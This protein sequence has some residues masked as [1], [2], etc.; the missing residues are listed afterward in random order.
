MTHESIFEIYH[1]VCKNT[2]FYTNYIRVIFTTVLRR[3]F[4]TA[5]EHRVCETGVKQVFTHVT[6]WTSP[7]GTCRF[8]SSAATPARACAMVAPAKVKGQASLKKQS[9]LLS[10]PPPCRV[11][12]GLVCRSG[13]KHMAPAERLSSRRVSVSGEKKNRQ[14]RESAP[15]GGDSDECT[16]FNFR[17]T[18]FLVR[19]V[20][21]WICRYLEGKAQSR[22]LLALSK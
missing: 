8:C 9:L 22:W 19:S 4:F 3:I 1:M 20:M 15:R 18:H 7:M 2:I 6:F 21:R 14:T 5:G 10:C 16:T 12:H 17:A 11:L 13:F